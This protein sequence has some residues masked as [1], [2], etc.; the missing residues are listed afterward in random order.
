MRLCEHALQGTGRG[1]GDLHAPHANRCQRAKLQKFE[2]DGSGCGLRQLRSLQGYAPQ[3]GHEHISQRGEPQPQLVGA[4]ARGRGPVREE[5]ELAF[6]DTILHVAAG[7]VDFLVKLSCFNGFALERGH[8]EARIFA[9]G[10]MLRLGYDATFA[11]P[12][13]EGLVAQLLEE[14]FRLAASLGFGLNLGQFLCDQSFKPRIAGEA[15]DVVNAVSF[16]PGH[17]IVPA[18]A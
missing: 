16:T 13:V 5:V 3:G 7:A 9:F 12:A 15:E 4:Q 14:A 18:E 6:L 10:K 2:P 8:D 1:N 11:T 17:E